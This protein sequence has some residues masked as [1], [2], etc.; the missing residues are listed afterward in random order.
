MREA[1]TDIKV[2]V[3]VSLDMA[4]TSVSTQYAHLGLIFKVASSNRTIRAQYSERLQI[5]YVISL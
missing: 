4:V 5:K 2:H 3:S 1:N